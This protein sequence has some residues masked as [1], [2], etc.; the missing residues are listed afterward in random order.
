[1]LQYLV[2]NLD[3][4]ST[5]YC[6][7]EINCGSPNLIGLDKLQKGIRFAM[8]EN[9]SVQVVYPDYLIPKEYKEAIDAVDHYDI[10]SSLCEDK[11]LREHADITILHDCIALDKYPFDNKKTYVLRITI[12]D[13][14]DR[15][16]FIKHVLHE[17]GRLNI[18]FTDIENFCDEDIQKYNEALSV[19]SSTIEDCYDK[20]R[21]VQLNLLTDR[22]TLATMR[23]CNAG[24]DSVT[25]APDGNFYIC[26]A[27]YYANEDEDY[28]LGKSKTNVGDLENGLNIK[29]ARLYTLENAHLCSLCDAYHCQRCVWLNRK[30]TYEVNTPSHEQ[31]VMAHLERNQTKDLMKRLRDKGFCFDQKIKDINYLDPFVIRREW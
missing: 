25:L 6:H 26:P 31:C 21:F 28:G 4:I 7:Y 9:L 19:L 5:S 15:Y 29:N 14:L 10:V 18:I 23:N 2:I 27:F 12:H 30:F 20:G 11:E 8:K 1:M 16:L 13:F 22:L 3:D 24:V 17:A